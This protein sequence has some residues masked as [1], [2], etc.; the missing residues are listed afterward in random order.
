ME[1]VVR[2]NASIKVKPDICIIRLNFSKVA[3]NIE[4]ALSEG[5]KMVYDTFNNLSSKFGIGKEQ[6][7]TTNYNVSENKVYDNTNNIVNAGYIFNQDVEIK[8]NYDLYQLALI[9]DEIAQMDFPI[10][11]SLSFDVDNIDSYRSNLLGDAYQNALTDAK[12]IANSA[13]GDIVAT[14]RVEDDEYSGSAFLTRSV[15]SGNIDE[16]SKTFTP[17]DILIERSVKVTFL[18]N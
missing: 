15:I 16:F 12:K 6:F 3:D 1:I 11:Y 18:A 9:I 13:K 4:T 10:N 17:N 7:V 14:L 2:G 8:I 5:S